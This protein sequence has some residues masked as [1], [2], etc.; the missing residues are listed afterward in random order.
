MRTDIGSLYSHINIQDYIQTNKKQF[1]KEI[2]DLQDKANLDRQLKSLGHRRKLIRA[3]QFLLHCLSCDAFI[4]LST[5]IKKIEMAHHVIVDDSLDQR[6]N[7]T[8]RH[9]SFTADTSPQYCGKVVCKECG[10]NLGVICIYKGIEFPVP[11]IEHFLIKDING[12]H[13]TC[14]KW[15]KA[16]FNVDALNTNDLRKIIQSRSPAGGL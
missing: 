2:Y 7:F 4:C 3:G 1:E 13:D 12:R 14:K 11:K 15:N 8:E 5:D 6:V 9:S 16:P 10:R